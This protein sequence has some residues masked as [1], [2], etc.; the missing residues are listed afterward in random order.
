[1]VLKSYRLFKS[2]SRRSPKRVVRRVGRKLSDVGS[3][4]IGATGAI[5]GLGLLGATTAAVN[6]I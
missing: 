5:L 1:M 4:A 6:R 3:L 2:N